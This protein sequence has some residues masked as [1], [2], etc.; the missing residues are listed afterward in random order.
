LLKDAV[1]AEPDKW[2]GPGHLA[3]YG[4]DTKLLVKL[5]DAGQ[6]LPVHAHPHVDWSRKHLGRNHGKA[7]A[8]YV[9]TP[10]SVWLGLKQSVSKKELL[11]L[12][13]AGRGAELLQRMHKL[14]VVPHQTVYVPPGTLHAIGEGILVVEVQEPEDL[15]IL[16]EWK[17]FAIDG[18]RDGHLG[19][20]FPTALSAVD[21]EARTR[22]QV[23]AW[24]T[25]AQ[26]TR[27]I[28]VPDSSGYFR[29]ERV[30]VNGPTGTERGF[31]ILVVLNGR[32]SLQ[33]CQSEPLN[34]TKGSTVVIPHQDGELKLQGEGDVLLARP[35]Q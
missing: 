33:T 10:G 3:K 20:G 29:L 27:S 15:S 6:R 5:L 1:A 26:V 28:C 21:C 12:V 24:V 16:C 17:G 22:A 2:L 7:E 30:H 4:A 8:W 32:V 19:L 13:E 34:L 31:A 14:D 11:D 25:S 18:K 9:L 23:E 35:P